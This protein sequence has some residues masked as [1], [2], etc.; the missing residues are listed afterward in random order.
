M[1]VTVSHTMKIALRKIQL[2][3]QALKIPLIA[4]SLGG[5]ESLVT[6]PAQTTHYCLSPEERKVGIKRQSLHR[7]CCNE[8]SCLGERRRDSSKRNLTDSLIL[9]LC[10]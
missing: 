1:S 8:R 7:R 6:I 3:M 2:H 10:P 4:P 5:V 9:N